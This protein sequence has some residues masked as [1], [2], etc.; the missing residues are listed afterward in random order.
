MFLTRV[1]E[2]EPFFFFL[3]HNALYFFQ[4]YVGSSKLSPPR[5]VWRKKVSRYFSVL[6]TAPFF[7]S[8]NCFGL[9]S[10]KDVEIKICPVFRTNGI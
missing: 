10:E 3:P 7:E 5:N 1:L 2:V 6:K 4:A 9:C 8:S